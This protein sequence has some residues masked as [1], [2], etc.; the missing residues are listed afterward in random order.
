MS[1]ETLV[2][3]AAAAATQRPV[4]PFMPRTISERRRIGVVKAIQDGL[5]V[6]G[7]KCPKIVERTNH[8]PT[9]AERKRFMDL[10]KR[11]D[12][13]AQA[14]GIDPTL[15]ASRGTLSDLA[16]SWEKYSPELMNWQRELLTK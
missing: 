8:R 14:L 11:R 6:T 12:A 7:D 5:G 10:Q 15:I 2:D 1:H 13:Q 4:D 9:E 16:R 3:I